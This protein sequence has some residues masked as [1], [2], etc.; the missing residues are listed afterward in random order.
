MFLDFNENVHKNISAVGFNQLC[1]VKSAQ[2]YG[3]D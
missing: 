1:A 3:S 2:F